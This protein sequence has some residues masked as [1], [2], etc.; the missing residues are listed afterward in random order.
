MPDQ[1][2]YDYVICHPNKLVDL[3]RAIFLS[4]RGTAHR[5]SLVDSVGSPDPIP[6][7]ESITRLGSYPELV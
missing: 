6:P 3:K 7:R 1:L 5:L 4:A 2:R